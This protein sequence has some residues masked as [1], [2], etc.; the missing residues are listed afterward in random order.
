MKI[1]KDKLKALSLLSDTELWATICE[2]AKG[3]G[4][5]VPLTPPSPA[6]MQKIREAMVDPDRLSIA[7]ALRLINKHRKG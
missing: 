1:D 5:S 4:I 2:V 3:H 7:G 6:D